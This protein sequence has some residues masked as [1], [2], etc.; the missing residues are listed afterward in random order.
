[1]PLPLSLLPETGFQKCQGDVASPPRARSEP[2]CR[3]LP[4][5]AQCLLPLFSSLF[6]VPEQFGFSQTPPF[7]PCMSTN[8]PAAVG[9]REKGT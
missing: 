8:Y 5:L 2:F 1:M 4:P 9:S 7:Q 6:T 3:F